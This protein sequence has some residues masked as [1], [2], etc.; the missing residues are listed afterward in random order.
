M[1]RATLDI[2][3]PS[4]WQ[5]IKRHKVSALFVIFTASAI[6]YDLSLTRKKKEQEKE[7]SLV[8]TN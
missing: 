8:K 3:K 6:W 5:S 1:D 2:K 4:T 7:K